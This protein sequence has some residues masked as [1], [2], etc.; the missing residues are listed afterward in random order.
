MLCTM[1]WKSIVKRGREKS[2]RLIQ[3]RIAG[4]SGDCLLLPLWEG[5]NTMPPALS[6]TG[7]RGG[8]RRDGNEV[9]D[10]E[11]YVEHASAT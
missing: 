10:S 7:Y 8:K 2:G 6:W 3:V 4:E 1:L 11:Q 5:G 9:I